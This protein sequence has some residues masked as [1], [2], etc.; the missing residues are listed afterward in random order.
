MLSQF[1]PKKLLPY[2]TSGSI[3]NQSACEDHCRTRV[4]D[5]ANSLPSCQ[6]TSDLANRANLS[7]MKTRPTLGGMR[8]EAPEDDRVT[9]LSAIRGNNIFC[10]LG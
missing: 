2:W 4:I 1:K 10:T 6:S 9:G 8:I 5:A 7:P 3:H